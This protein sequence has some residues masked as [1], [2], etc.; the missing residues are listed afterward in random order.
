MFIFYNSGKV[1]LYFIR[2]GKKNIQELWRK[3]AELECRFLEWLL[4]SGM[5]LDRF[6]SEVGMGRR[7]RGKS[8]V[9]NIFPAYFIL[10]SVL[11]NGTRKYTVAKTSRVFLFLF[12]LSFNA[13]TS[14][15]RSVFSGNT[16]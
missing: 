7:C 13:P 4:A 9:S 2:G 8:V 16:S 1:D 11:F 10:G 6:F 12:S 14:S 3:K 15:I 5:A